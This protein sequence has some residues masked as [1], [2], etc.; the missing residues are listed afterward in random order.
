MENRIKEQMQ[1][2][3]ARTSAHGWWTNQWRLLLSGLA[4]VLMESLRRLAL[5]GTSLARAQ[6]STLRLKL[7]KIGAVITRNTRTIRVHL[8]SA[9]PL[10]TF[11][12]QILHRLRAT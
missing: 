5:Q 6:M 8:C 9:Y 7:V 4:Y 12:W 10:H 1:L 11:F 3:S 2:F